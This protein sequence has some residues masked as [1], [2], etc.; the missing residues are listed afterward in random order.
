MA[1]RISH[2][3]NG[4]AG[5]RKINNNNCANGTGRDW[6]LF[7]DPGYDGGRL[8]LPPPD[9]SM[10]PRGDRTAGHIGA[11]KIKDKDGR[12]GDGRRPLPSVR[13]AKDGSSIKPVPAVIKRWE[14]TASA[15]CFLDGLIP[16]QKAPEPK[17]LKSKMH[18]LTATEQQK[19]DSQFKPNMAS[20]PFTKETFPVEKYRYHSDVKLAEA[21]MPQLPILKKVPPVATTY[22]DGMREGVSKCPPGHI[23][24][25]SPY[26]NFSEDIVRQS[27]NFQ[28]MSAADGLAGPRRVWNTDEGRMNSSM[29]ATL[30]TIPK[31]IQK[32][33]SLPGL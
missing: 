15:P 26:H 5:L 4:M 18:F 33:M 21:M 32:A 11:P 27:P 28:T 16:P 6:A 1:V 10:P 19:L 25:I 2:R 14:K 29:Q 12:V 8:D 13:R 17:E 7:G 20:Y 31:N 3:G 23:P 9:M 30:A 22:A 24:T